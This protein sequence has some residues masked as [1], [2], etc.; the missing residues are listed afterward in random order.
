MHV[1]KVHK[2]LSLAR[3]QL[4]APDAVAKSIDAMLK[5]TKWHGDDAGT[6]QTIE[7]MIGEIRKAH[8]IRS[9]VV[10]LDTKPIK[11]RSDEMLTTAAASAIG[12]LRKAVEACRRDDK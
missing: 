4:E 12:Y 2:N 3:T 10:V 1:E 9:P 11:R 8:T 5:D 6:E 7:G